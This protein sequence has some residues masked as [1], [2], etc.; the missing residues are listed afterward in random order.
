MTTGQV[1]QLALLACTALLALYLIWRSVLS[2]RRDVTKRIQDV[3]ADAVSQC[4]RLPSADEIVSAWAQIPVPDYP[5]GLRDV[6]RPVYRLAV[7]EPS[8]V[9][10]LFRVAH[11]YVD[12][13]NKSIGEDIDN[14]LILIP[15]FVRWDASLHQRLLA[16]L[17]LVVPVIWVR[18]IV[19]PYARG[20]L[21]YRIARLLD[22][23]VA[24]RAL[25]PNRNLRLSEALRVEYQGEVFLDVPRV[26]AMD[27][28]RAW[29]MWAFTP[30]SITTASKLA[31]ER[32][33][34]RLSRE[35]A[36]HGVSVADLSNTKVDLRW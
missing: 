22:I 26:R 19:N 20:R 8:S 12:I 13:L 28:I 18:S 2:F 24:L 29:L 11:R 15:Q 25:S 21:G 4:H 3:L 35:L 7:A 23:L 32:E 30:P 14:Q 9:D 6:V 17:P 10:E 1:A 5:A 34:I 27:A 31:Q 33:R 16:E 36:E